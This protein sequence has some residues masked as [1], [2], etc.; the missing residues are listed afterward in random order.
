MSHT[1]NL[2]SFAAAANI[3]GPFLPD[4]ATL[5][6]LHRAW[7]RTIPFENIEVLLGRPVSIEVSDIADKLLNRK[8]GGYCFEHNILLKTILEEVGFSVTPHLARVVWGMDAPQPTPQTHILLLVKVEGEHYIADVGFGGVNLSAPLKL[9]EGEQQ[10]F[11]LERTGTEQWLLSL[12]V[13]ES[14]KMMYVFD[15]KPCEAADILVASHFVATH[16]SSVF[17]HNLMMTGVVN[18]VQHNLFNQ[19]LTAYG[20]EKTEQHM[21]TFDEFRTFVSQFFKDPDV[22]S[23]E[24]MQRLY[25]KAGH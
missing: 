9:Q 17:R 19:R 5:T 22:L 23:H 20:H 24:D 14:K 21:Q 10:G 16:E 18:D 7:P 13:A 15:E 2:T 12:G 8:R 11:T 3:S 25:D 4:N 6:T 1:E